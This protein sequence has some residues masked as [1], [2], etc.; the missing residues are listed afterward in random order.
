MTVTWHPRNLLITV[1]LIAVF[2][3][4]LNIA[5]EFQTGAL[6]GAGAFFVYLL[7]DV[8]LTLNPSPRWWERPHHRQQ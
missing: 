6:M 8:L 1:V 7:V 2:A 3:V 4:A 5:I